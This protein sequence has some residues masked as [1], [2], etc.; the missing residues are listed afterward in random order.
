M[1]NARRVRAYSA[2]NMQPDG[3]EPDMDVSRKASFCSD[4]TIQRRLHS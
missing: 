3:V 2:V 1:P 4:V